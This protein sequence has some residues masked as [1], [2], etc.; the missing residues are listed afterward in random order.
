MPK[1]V[2][3]KLGGARLGAGRPKINPEGYRKYTTVSLPDELVKQLEKKALLD[4]KK[5]GQ[6]AT[7]IIRKYLDDNNT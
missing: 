7:E 2:K 3:K 1:E 5:K 6:I 4:G